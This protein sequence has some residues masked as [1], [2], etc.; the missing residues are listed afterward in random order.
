MH[1]DEEPGRVD[2]AMDIPQQPGLAF[3]VDLNLQGDELHLS[4]GVFHLQWFPCSRYSVVR[5]YRE[6]VQGLL[7]GV[8]R[9]REHYRGGKPFK[10]ELQRP[11]LDGWETVGT[12]RAWVWPL[13]RH[14]VE[15]ILQNVAD[16]QP[17]S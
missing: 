2:L 17:L 16:S 7:S 13:P 6:A 14:T 9:I 12:W 1:L 3:E 11:Y 15:R 10:A 5:A 4:A 8:Y